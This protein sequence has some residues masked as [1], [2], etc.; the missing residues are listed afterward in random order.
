MT[1]SRQILVQLAHTDLRGKPASSSPHSQG[2]EEVIETAQ[3]H[4]L[5]NY[6]KTKAEDIIKLQMNEG[7]FPI[8]K[9][10]QHQMDICKL[11][12]YLQ[13]RND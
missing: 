9:D 12:T 2:I 4:V 3:L 6:G 11:V 13:M 8:L 7:T 10:L 5:K 1:S